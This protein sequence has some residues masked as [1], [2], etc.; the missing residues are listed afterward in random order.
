MTPVKCG[1]NVASVTICI[2]LAVGFIEAPPVALP[3]LPS[4]NTEPGAPTL[5]SLCA[6]RMRRTLS[7]C[8]TVHGRGPG[9][10]TPSAQCTVAR[11]REGDAASTLLPPGTHSAGSGSVLSPPGTHSAGSGSVLSPPGTHSAGSGS[12]L[13]PPG[14]H[15]AGPGSVLSPLGTHSA[16]S[17][18]VLTPRPQ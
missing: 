6:W 12:V 17:G 9:H 7:Q 18:S 14:T 2:T 4:V 13:S 8:M 3:W 5:Y 15:S 16:G 1:L 10:D 11:Q